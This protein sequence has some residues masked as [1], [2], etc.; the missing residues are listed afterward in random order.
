MPI[1]L[2][3]GA[4]G[5]TE[6]ARLI[7]SPARV[8]IHG[9]AA[10]PN[11]FLE[12]LCQ[13]ARSNAGLRSVELIHLHTHGPALYQQP[14]FESQF[15]IASL[16]VGANLRSGVDFDRNDYIPCFLSEMPLLFR[17][18]VRPLDV[19]VLQV[20]PPDRNGYCSLGTSVDAARAAFDT[21]RIR[22]A[23]INQSVPRTMGDAIVDFSRFTHSVAADA[24]LAASKRPQIGEIELRIGQNVAQYIEDG[25]TLQMG[26]GA[27]PDACLQALKGHRDLG[28]HTE[29]W[30]D[31]A[32][33]LMEKGV[34][35][36]ARKRIH[37]GKTVSTFVVGS[38]RV[39]DFVHD[40]PGLL[41]L[42]AAYV[43]N[44]TVIARNPRVVAINSAVEVDLTGQ[45][46]ADSVGH[47][48]ISGVG[49]QV[50]FIRGATLSEGGKPIIAFT[51]RSAKGH[52]RIVAQLASGAG[53]VTTRAHTHIVATEYGAVDLFGRSIGERARLLISIAHP[54][55]RDLL[56]RDWAAVRSSHR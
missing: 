11:H 44:P 1:Q 6:A 14:E 45:I 4:R 13:H 40:N 28:I 53:V 49:G 54:E 22:I 9:G 20:S 35:T 33:D 27:V 3:D 46:C 21:A 52:P 29:M 41:L 34:I 32:L 23:I 16:F 26:I 2:A 15:R 43:N 7:P 56:E 25:S 48:I 37:A 47:H 17:R 51:S 30:T 12:A 24:P 55:D 5:L 10:T 36:N 38:Q 18:G 50:D 39:F 8:F 19:A 42:D 31:G